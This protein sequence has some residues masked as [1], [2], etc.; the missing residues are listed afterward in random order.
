MISYRLRISTLLLLSMLAGCSDSD[1]TSK[2]LYFLF[3][4]EYNIPAVGDA[5]IEP[6][7]S[8]IIAN[9]ISGDPFDLALDPGTGKMYLALGNLSEIQTIHT[10]NLAYSEVVYDGLGQGVTAIAIDPGRNKMYWFD[11]FYGKFSEGRLDGK[12][13]P[14]KLFKDQRVASRCSGMAVDTQKNILYFID[15]DSSKIYAADLA[16]E[17]MPVEIVSSDNSE[18]DQPADLV[19]SGDGSW[20][21]WSDKKN[22]VMVTNTA[23]NATE[24]FIT[25]AAKALYLNAQTNEL[26]VYSGWNVFKTSLIG[27]PALTEILEEPSI[28]AFV[29]R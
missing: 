1:N 28:T 9:H 2:H 8:A 26:Y 17:T 25:I 15:T 14:A 3:L 4:D 27:P 19:I 16:A 6:Q 10:N 5:Q 12:S 29:V 22:R 11:Y 23:T 13:S 20:L 21:Y 18:I 7:G 24:V